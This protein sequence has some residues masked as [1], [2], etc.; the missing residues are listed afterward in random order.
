M[1]MN[2]K[3]AVVPIAGSASGRMILV[4][5]PQWPAAVD[6]GRVV[7]V[8]RQGPDELNHQEHE[9]RIRRQEVRCDRAVRTC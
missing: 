1:L 9:E 6:A 7:E 4:K 5:T 2:V 3:S 8:T